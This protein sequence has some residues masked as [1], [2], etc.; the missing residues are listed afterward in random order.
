MDA[1]VACVDTA[2]S[3]YTVVGDTTKL[4]MQGRA[5]Q[6]SGLVSYFKGLP[7]VRSELEGVMANGPWVMASERVRWT[8]TKSGPQERVSI[9]VYEIRDGLIKRVWYFP[10]EKPT[11]P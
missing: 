1:L 5:A 9:S 2:F 7:D 3:W 6:R 10:A 8:S 11:K 4:A